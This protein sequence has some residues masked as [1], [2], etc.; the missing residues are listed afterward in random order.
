MPDEN[1]PPG[2]PEP[3]DFGITALE[4]SHYL[5]MMR[6]GRAH[7]LSLSLVKRVRPYEEALS[8]WAAAHGIGAREGGNS[9]VAPL[10]SN[11]RQTEPAE[12]QSQ[13][14][15]QRAPNGGAKADRDRTNLVA[16]RTM[17]SP[18]D[19]ERGKVE[20]HRR[21]A[22]QKIAELKAQLAKNPNDTA[23]LSDL[24]SAQA[25]LNSA[26]QRLNELGAGGLA[27]F[28]PH[29]NYDLPDPSLAYDVLGESIGAL[30]MHVCQIVKM[31]MGTTL[32]LDSIGR[33]RWY[34]TQ[35]TGK[36]PLPT[37]PFFVSG[38]NDERIIAAANAVR[39][40]YSQGRQSVSNRPSGEEQVAEQTKPGPPPNDN[41][42]EQIVAHIQQRLQPEYWQELTARGLELEL[43][44]VFA[45][46]GYEDVIVTWEGADD[47]VDL[48]LKQGDNNFIVQCKG[49]AKPVSPRV[50]RELIG[51][52]QL[53][54]ADE[55]I[56]V[57]TSGFTSNARIMAENSGIF[58][59][60]LYGL[61]D[62]S[63]QAK[64][65]MDSGL[66]SG[67]LTI[68]DTPRCTEPGCQRLMVRARSAHAELWRCSKAGC[69]GQRWLKRR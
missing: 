20:T 68:D 33:A 31:E 11:R 34:F 47:G 41:R 44:C 13:A 46:R 50:I 21:V 55:A 39:R 54:S 36:P 8:L 43:G 6:E 16:S 27:A 22:E 59:L 48:I 18:P 51:S 64:A 67:N 28:Q 40:R 57:S 52:S 2:K 25:E 49:Q 26:N 29:P 23:L 4:H 30:W 19:T 12:R 17:P 1:Q 9:T 65:R 35:I 10:P 14:I 5:K 58:L 37:W 3:G 62:V 38:T 61:I 15:R 66:P 69:S 7:L 60:D 56:L 24:R 53:Y 63:S 45:E 32:D 42:E